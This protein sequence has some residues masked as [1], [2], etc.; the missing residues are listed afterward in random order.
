VEY[1]RT[2]GTPSTLDTQQAVRCQFAEIVAG[3]PVGDQ[4]Q[5][6]ILAVAD[7]PATLQIIKQP[8]LARIERDLC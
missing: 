3:C 8:D 1:S 5:F 2:G 4:E 7:T 6:L